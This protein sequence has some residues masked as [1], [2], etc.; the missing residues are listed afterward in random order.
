MTELPTE[1][2]ALVGMVFLLGLKHGIDPDHIVV[3]DGIARQNAKESP[4]LAR[5][6]G[7][8]FSLGHGFVVTLVAILVATA[9]SAWK[10]PPWL[11]H[12]GAAVSIF[13]LVALAVANVRAVLKTPQ[14]QVV[15]VT[16]VK[17]H[18]LGHVRGMARVNHPIAIASIGAAFA[19]S[20]DTISHAVV[21]SL[22]GSSIAGWLFSAI[23]GVAF[24]LG[25]MAT[26]ALNGW[27]MSAMLQRAD[28]RA[29]LA[30]RVMSLAIAGLSLFIALVGVSKYLSLP[31]TAIMPETPAVIGLSVIAFTIFVFFCAL[32][33]R[34]RKHG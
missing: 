21:F 29:A 10:A 23:L 7:V 20:F 22:A 14:G 27:W 9:A 28:Q 34:D 8:L 18:L 24:T 16:G 3:I 33:L 26:D 4:R 30:S 15:R 2:A 1:W 6:S 12:T 13:F 32:N 11:E 19:L 17:S 5:L 25:M 31:V